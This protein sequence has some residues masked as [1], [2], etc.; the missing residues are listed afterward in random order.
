[1]E[2]EKWAPKAAQL[3]ELRPRCS[4][5]CVVERAAYLECGEFIG[6]LA[7]VLTIFAPA[8]SSASST[9]AT[10]STPPTMAHTDVR[11]LDRGVRRSVTRTMKGDRSYLHGHT[12]AEPHSDEPAAHHASCPTAG[13]LLCMFER[14]CPLCPCS[15]TKKTPGMR[16]ASPLN[17][18]CSEMSCA[19]S[20]TEN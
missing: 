1:M 10:V 15:D 14:L 18:S 16:C 11:K 9:P 3:H 2:A 13:C 17:A 20:V 6:V 4:A 7:F 5:H 8:K 19:C 12:A